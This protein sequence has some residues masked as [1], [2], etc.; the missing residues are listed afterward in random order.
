MKKYLS[1]FR[2]RFI[3]SLQYRGAALAGVSTQ[4][5]W[6]FMELLL[7]KA[8]FE[9]NAAA[10]PMGMSQL[11]C[12]VWLKQAFLALFMTWSWESDLFEAI[13]SGTVAYDL[14]R[15]ADLYEMWFTRAA[16]T[17]CAK[18][19][20]R[21]V[22]VLAVAALLPAPYGLTLPASW[23]AFGWFVLTMALALID[24]VA[25][26]MIIYASAFF[27]VSPQGLRMVFTSAADLLSGQIIPLPFLPDGL[28]QVCELLPFASTLDVPLRIYSGSLTGEA[29]L[30][31]VGLQVFWAVALVLTGK[32]MEACGLK[33]VTL[34]GG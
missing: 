1:F 20:L 5:F 8:F 31:A 28:R 22:P 15:P 9:A 34:A 13:T 21:C 26:T 10:F 16:A 14:C 24:V 29:L 7:Y 33:K 2:I 27:M 23:A 4:F 3:H 30:R 12:Y 32:W 11:T 25:L 17:R 6:G 19:L 18:A